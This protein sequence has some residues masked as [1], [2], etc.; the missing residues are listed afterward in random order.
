MGQAPR[1]S[2]KEVEKVLK[3]LRKA[4]WTVVYPSGHW[5]RVECPDGCRVGVS[6]TPRDCTNTA[7]TTL[8]TARK[9]PHG[10]APRG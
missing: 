5:G 9:C 8:R 1:H 6:G 7:R 2:C 10:H 3:T 4:G